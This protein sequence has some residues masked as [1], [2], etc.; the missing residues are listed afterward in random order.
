MA[1]LR[2][3]LKVAT[4]EAARF[5]AIAE[6]NESF[7]FDS[8]HVAAHFDRAG[9]EA[10]QVPPGRLPSTHQ[11]IC[12][13][14][15]R[16]WLRLTC[17]VR[18]AQLGVS[19]RK[20]PALLRWAARTFRIKVPTRSIKVPDKKVG[21]KMTYVQCDV[22]YLYGETHA[23]LLGAMMLQI[24]KLQA[25]EWMGDLLSDEQASSCYLADGA[26]SLQH[27]WLATI[28]SKRGADGKLSLFAVDMKVMSSKTGEAQAARFREAMG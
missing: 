14:S 25:A 11:P 20:L 24:N 1:A 4:E 6:P 18:A 13:S 9:I 21:G 15:T 2:A 27:E 19:K 28:L 7:F 16:S 10:L 8:G 5:K 3:D 23:K 17:T 22:S 12:P 26:E